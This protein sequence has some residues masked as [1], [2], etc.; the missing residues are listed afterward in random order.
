[1]N[2]VENAIQHSPRGARVHI[3]VDSSSG[4]EC[5]VRIADSGSGISAVD[6][7]HVF[8]RFYRSDQSRSR[9]TGGFG[10]GLSIV[11]AVVEKSHGR[12]EIRSTPQGGTT[13]EVCLPAGQEQNVAARVG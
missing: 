5:R 4:S 8:E 2:L 12:I 1:M 7:P 13:V 10:L 6:L 3:E 9:Q 11:K